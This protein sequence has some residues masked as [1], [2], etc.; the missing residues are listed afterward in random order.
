M[1]SPYFYRLR[2]QHIALLDQIL[3]VKIRPGSIYAPNGLAM[4]YEGVLTM[5]SLIPHRDLF[6]R[7]A[8]SC[9]ARWSWLGIAWSPADRRIAFRLKTAVMCTLPRYRFILTAP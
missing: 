4:P 5:N 2:N 8:A 6:E 7:K 3:M 1:A 9:C